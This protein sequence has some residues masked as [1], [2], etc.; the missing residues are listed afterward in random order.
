MAQERRWAAIRLRAERKMGELLGPAENHGPAT[1]TASQVL[2]R[3]T[4]NARR[5]SALARW[6]PSPRTSS[7]PYFEQ[8][9]EP[10]PVQ[11][12][13]GLAPYFFLA[14][15]ASQRKTESLANSGRF[16]KPATSVDAV[17]RCT[18]AVS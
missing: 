15:N 10:T 7:M 8:A 18:F 3:P 14:L 1:V 2:T 12:Y 5:G 6:P 11:D 16:L 13:C 17:A 4:L 9:D